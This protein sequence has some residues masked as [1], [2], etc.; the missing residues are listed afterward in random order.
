MKCWCSQ[1]MREPESFWQSRCASTETGQNTPKQ[2]VVNGA[3]LPRSFLE[4]RSTPF[5]RGA[6]P[7]LGFDVLEFD[8]HLGLGRVER[9]HHIEADIH[10]IAKSGGIGAAVDREFR[11]A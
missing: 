10:R 8:A 1:K 3:L 5:Q 6:E 7:L 9:R 4:L 2:G 11:G